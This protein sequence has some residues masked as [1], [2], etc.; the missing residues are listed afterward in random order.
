MTF[1]GTAYQLYRRKLD[2]STTEKAQ[3]T[4]LLQT[5]SCMCGP[6]YYKVLSW[7][8]IEA[9]QGL[10]Y[11]NMYMLKSRSNEWRFHFKTSKQLT[12]I[13]MKDHHIYFCWLQNIHQ[14]LLVFCFVLLWHLALFMIAYSMAE[15]SLITFSPWS[16]LS[17]STDHVFLFLGP[18]LPKQIHMKKD[19]TINSQFSCVY[20][21]YHLCAFR[22]WPLT[23][24]WLL[25]IMLVPHISLYF[26]GPSGFKYQLLEKIV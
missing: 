3:P 4:K 2:D 1:P 19:L 5:R 16:Q 11:I 21:L 10:L 8:G 18:S 24:L 14:I 23:F 9:L 25:I 17:S 13:A 12:G 20:S 26:A 7:D 15:S 6:A 22:L